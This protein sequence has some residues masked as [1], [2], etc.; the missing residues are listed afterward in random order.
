MEAE[1]KQLEDDLKARTDEITAQWDQVLDN[2][3]TTEIKLR[4]TDVNVE[5]TMLGWAPYWRIT[6]ND[7]ARDRTTN[8][9]AH[10]LPEV[11]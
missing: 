5:A 3:T 9:P 11:G 8:V 1:V 6:Y 7:G 10:H 2:I 4:R